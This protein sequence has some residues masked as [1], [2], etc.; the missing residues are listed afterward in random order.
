[1]TVTQMQAATCVALIIVV[2]VSR[3]PAAETRPAERLYAREN[4]VAWCIV[5]FD[6]KKRGPEERAA[7]LARLGFRRFA[8]D[9]RA[10]HLPTFDDELKSLKANK[11]EL[12]AV[13]FPAALNDD[14]R[15][16]L[17]V[18]KRHAIRTQLWVT[19]GDPAAWLKR[20]RQVSGRRC[21]ASPHCR[22]RQRTGLLSGTLQ[23]RR[24]VWPARKPNRNHSRAKGR[25]RRH[26]LQPAPWPRTPRSI[27]DASQ[28]NEAASVR[29]QS[30]WDGA[31]RR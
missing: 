7:M 12:T 26:C 5:P 17:G 19:M 2:G 27:R 6:A 9:W 11:I 20:R 16:I 21:S 3:S 31:Q 22:R 13:W 14:A 28:G 4:L 30:Q 10:E 23:P 29:H 15:T 24:M 25:E 18:L 8:Y 1:M